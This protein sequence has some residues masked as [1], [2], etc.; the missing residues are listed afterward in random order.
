MT[1]ST[2]NSDW[3]ARESTDGA[4]ARAL[5]PSASADAISDLREIDILVKTLAIDVGSLE[6][7]F[8]E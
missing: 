1:L 5:R 3:T 4:D 8:H 7:S 2:T 6:R